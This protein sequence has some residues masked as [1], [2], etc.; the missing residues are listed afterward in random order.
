M[1]RKSVFLSC[2]L[3]LPATFSFAGI[4]EDVRQSLAQ[5]DFSSAEAALNAY[6]TRFGITPE[7][8]EALSWM[9]RAALARQQY[10]QAASYAR[11]TQSLA[12]PLLK[13]RSLD[14]DEHLAAAV[15]AAYE[16]QAQALA[17]QGHKAQASALLRK[18]LQIYGNTSIANRLHKNLNLLT[19]VGQPAPALKATE[20]LGAPPPSAAQL[21]GTPQLLF[22]WAHWCADCKGEAPIIA[23]LRSEFKEL[24]ILAP[25]Q[26]Y[27]YAERGEDT[28]PQAELAYI[29]KV[30]QQYYP[31]L[32]GVP[33]PVNKTNF[34]VYGSSTTP[35]LVLIDRNGKI[36]Y[37]HPGAVSYEELRVA[38]EKVTRGQVP[39]L[40]TGSRAHARETPGG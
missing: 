7:Y 32:Q 21:K 15:G 33:V 2:L 26:R 11:Q 16:V 6:K 39:Q 36:A 9:G 3:A 24:T 4:V 23:R 40:P 38:I 22:F 29:R 14:S 5:G 1:L 17:G 8:L 19:L 35:T 30:W 12:V 10:P 37:Y 28:T 34:T 31:G 25:T 20:N 18:A 13:A 27:G